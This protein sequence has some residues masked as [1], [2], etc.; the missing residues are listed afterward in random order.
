MP[1]MSMGAERA[2]AQ[3]QDGEIE[4]LGEK[5]WEAAADPDAYPGNDP[6]AARGRGIA[7]RLFAGLL[8]LLALGWIGASGYALTRAWPGPSLGAWIGWAATISAPLILLGL[9]WLIFGRSSRRETRRFTEAVRA[10]RGESEALE[11]VLAITATKLAENRAALNEESAGLMSLGDEATERL[12][13]VTQQLARE[14]AE[15]DR[16]AQALDSAAEAARVDIGVL[17]NDLPKAE[18]QARAAAEA[19]KQAGL[20]AHE[21]AAAL[22]GQ[23]A[24]LTAR[25]READEGAGG[26]AQRLG[27]HIARIESGAEAAAGRMNEASVQ[28]EAAV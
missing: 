11:A 27:A 28:M 25:A 3:P 7:V 18:A 2:E 5:P 21:Q 17:M 10:M 19:M 8:I 9:L 20:G 26:A 24:A 15:L 12:G 16:K 1:C 13:R 4:W 22:E 23:L 14:T 6:E